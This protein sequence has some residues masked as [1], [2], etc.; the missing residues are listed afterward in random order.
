MNVRFVVGV[1]EQDV[2]LAGGLGSDGLVV[3]VGDTV[4][5]PE[6]PHSA[7]VRAFLRHVRANGFQA[8]PTPLGHDAQGREILTYLPGDV[9]HPPMP[10]WAAAEDLLVSVARLQR[11]LHA[12]SRGFVAPADAVWQTANL[13]PFPPDAPVCHNDLCVQNVVVVAGRAAG[14]I[15]F[16]FAAPSDPLLDIAIAVRHW[17]PVRAE[18]DLPQAW[19]GTDPRRRFALF[20]DIHDLDG[21]ARARVVDHLGDFLDRALISMRTRAEQGRPGYVA[22]WQ[23]GYEAQNRRS[24]EAVER[25]RP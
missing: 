13:P 16:D 23:A 3:R 2:A 4:R 11:E 25:L 5:R 1:P 8:V 15:D 9:A 10:I 12:A 17:V 19:R 21:D 6:R 22:I 14:I 7:S 24:R 20:C 18:E